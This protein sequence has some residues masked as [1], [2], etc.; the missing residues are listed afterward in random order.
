MHD[1]PRARVLL[2]A[3]A[4]LAVA[5]GCAPLNYTHPVQPYETFCCV[6]PPASTES[7][8]VVSYNIRFS[9]ELPLAIETLQGSPT[10]AASDVLLLQEMD[11][12]GARRVARALGMNLVYYPAVRHPSSDRDF[13]NA[14]LSRWPVLRHRKLILPHRGRFGRTQRIGVLAVIAVGGREVTVS[15][16]HLATPIE[17]GPGKRREQ[18]DAIA[19]FAA[20]TKSDLVLIGG[21]LNDSGLPT[22]FV[23]RG[24]ACPTRRIG[25]TSVHGFALD[26]VLVRR[27]T[28]TALG[29]SLAA[30]EDARSPVV[31]VPSDGVVSDHYP[32]WA[33]IPLTAPAT[34]MSAR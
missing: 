26:H 25:S 10:L 30:L 13:G 8:L 19:D 20:A 28:G 14:V 29:D 17:V 21:D 4:V 27:R 9:H 32:I 15:S 5:A 7:L 6:K 24:Y 12:I 11:G 31:V 23:E 3:L 18:V 1:R 16:V 22:R 34:S 33:R 2:G